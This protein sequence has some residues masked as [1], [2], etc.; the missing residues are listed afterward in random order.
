M[1]K[2]QFNKAKLVSFI[3]NTIYESLANKYGQ[4]GDID[5][6]QS[7]ANAHWGNVYSVMPKGESDNNVF[8]RVTLYSS[9]GAVKYLKQDQNGK[10]FFMDP[11]QKVWRPVNPA[12]VAPQTEC[13][14][15]GCGDPND[16]HKDDMQGDTTDV[17]TMDAVNVAEGI[18]YRKS[19][20]ELPTEFAKWK[21]ATPADTK[22]HNAVAFTAGWNAA[23]ASTQQAG[24]NEQNSTASATPGGQ[25]GGTIKT[26]FAFSKKGAG[27]NKATQ[28][29]TGK[30][31]GY[32]LVQKPY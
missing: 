25:E 18:D 9:V 6:A 2:A 4:G 22:A 31:V 30:G 7:V 29:T 8:Y 26:P 14:T 16:D 13:A 3:K 28:A 27:K 5:N 12:I 32:K 15:C 1:K 23:I 11:P 17:H 19:S 20:A 10:W 24:L 21:A